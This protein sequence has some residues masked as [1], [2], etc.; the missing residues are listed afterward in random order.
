MKHKPDE[1]SKELEIS[2]GKSAPSTRTIYKW[3]TRFEVKGEDL[4]DRLRIGRQI[5][6]TCKNIIKRK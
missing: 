2:Y 1:I 6:A 5:T 3:F 4:E